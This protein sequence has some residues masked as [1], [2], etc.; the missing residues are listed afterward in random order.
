MLVTLKQSKISR[1]RQSFSRIVGINIE[2]MHIE[3]ANL[4]R[5]QMACFVLA[6]AMERFWRCQYTF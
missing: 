6:A 4:H 1:Q 5:N 3:H 2:W